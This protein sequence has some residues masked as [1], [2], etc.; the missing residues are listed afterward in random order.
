[1]FL[2]EFRV[3]RASSR[4]SRGTTFDETDFAAHLS[5]LSQHPV[6]ETHAEKKP[7]TS[8]SAFFQPLVV[9]FNILLEVSKSD[10]RACST[11]K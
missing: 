10:N 5:F 2:Q 7:I 8:E 3:N 1:M 9:Q 4:I 6:Q 11:K